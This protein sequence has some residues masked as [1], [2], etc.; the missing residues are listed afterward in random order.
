MRFKDV[1]EV[2]NYAVQVGDESLFDKIVGTA[3]QEALDSFTS[4]PGPIQKGFDANKSFPAFTVG[5]IKTQS[6][7][8]NSQEWLCPLFMKAGEIT[9]IGGEAKKS[10]KTT[11]LMHVLKAV[12]DG[13]PFMKMPTIKT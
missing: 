7:N 4:D 3:I 2:H 11:L 8:D 10:G 9:L 6:S 5:E 1:S 13:V 12:H